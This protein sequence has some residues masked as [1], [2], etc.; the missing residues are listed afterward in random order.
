L[1]KSGEKVV[2]KFPKLSKKKLSK[3]GQKAV[4]HLSNFVALARGPAKK[5]KK[6][7]KKKIGGSKTRYDFVA[8]GKNAGGLATLFVVMQM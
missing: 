1:L 5:K 2:K 3:I 8:P 4:E 6:K 7:K